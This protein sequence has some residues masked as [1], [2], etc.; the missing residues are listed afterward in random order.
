MNKLGFA[1]TEDKNTNIL[2]YTINDS[3][4]IYL[5]KYF[6][7]VPSNVVKFNEIIEEQDKI[8]KDEEVNKLLQMN[9]EEETMA[10]TIQPEEEE[11]EGK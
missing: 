11:T 3:N 8:Q 4:D 1:K 10:E 7:D 2:Q 5:D 6:V 9:K